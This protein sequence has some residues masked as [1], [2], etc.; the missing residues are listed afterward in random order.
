MKAAANNAVDSVH[1]LMAN[2]AVRTLRSYEQSRSHRM[3]AAGHRVMESLRVVD[4]EARDLLVQ[5][6]SELGR[7]VTEL[8]SLMTEA[9]HDDTAGTPPPPPDDA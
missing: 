1:R 8:A 5:D 4:R 9:S 3:K 2:P 7:V 6:V